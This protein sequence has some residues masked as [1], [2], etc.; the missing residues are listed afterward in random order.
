[1]WILCCSPDYEVFEALCCFHSLTTAKLYGDKLAK[2]QGLS[3][4]NLEWRETSGPIRLGIVDVEGVEK[5]FEQKSHFLCRKGHP[6]SIG[7]SVV[8]ATLSWVGEED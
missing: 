6:S 7:I 3:R 5:D 4:D 8:E 2:L 1:M